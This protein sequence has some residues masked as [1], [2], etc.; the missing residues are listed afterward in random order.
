MSDA[1]DVRCCRILVSIV[2]PGKAGKA[3]IEMQGASKL[4]SQGKQF[5]GK[6]LRQAGGR[7]R[8]KHESTIIG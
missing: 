2:Q 4:P 8:A 1:V 7:L 5:A 3:G 6:G